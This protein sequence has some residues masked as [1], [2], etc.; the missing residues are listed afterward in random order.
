GV[1]GFVRKH[2][3]DATGKK[4]GI[5]RMALL[6][7]QTALGS[8]SQ[9]AAGTLGHLAETTGL[10]QP[11]QAALTELADRARRQA[12]SSKADRLLKLLGE[13][14]D[15]MVVFTQFRAT[16]EMLAQRLEQAGQSVALF[17][18]G[19]TRLA[20]EAAINQFR[21]PARLLLTTDAGSEGRNLQF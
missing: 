10:A 20:K 4:G 2:L 1:A 19:L 9:A 6:A 18:G 17:H 12:G 11:D 7:L 14:E 8:S 5:T 13:S 16:Q 21:G 15:K 3:R